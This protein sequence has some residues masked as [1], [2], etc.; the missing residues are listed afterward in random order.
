MVRRSAAHTK[1]A[2]EAW[3]TLFEA[4]MLTHP[5]RQETLGEHGL[6]PND[7]RA[8]YSLDRKEGRA[9]GALARQW[10]CDPSTATWVVDR[11]ERTG[12]AERRPSPDDRRVKLV[13]LT[14]KGAKMIET[15]E[16]VFMEPPAAMGALD[17]DELVE[18]KTTLDKL[19]A[20]H[21]SAK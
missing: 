4:F 19:I 17:A 18:L 7:S 16:A 2:R 8:L 9:I 20:T 21:R 1:A 12:L 5:E 14:A 13:L 15:L 3:R 10:N 11:L 6:T